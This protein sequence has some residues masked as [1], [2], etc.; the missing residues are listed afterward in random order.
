MVLP[1][2]LRQR[3]VKIPTWPI[4]G[5]TEKNRSRAQHVVVHAVSDAFTPFAISRDTE[6]DSGSTRGA[7]VAQLHAQ[8]RP[9][10]RKKIVVAHRSR[11][12]TTVVHAL[13]DAFTPF[14]MGVLP[15]LFGGA[16]G[17]NRSR[18][19][20]AGKNRSR[21]QR[22]CGRSRPF[23]RVHALSRSACWRSR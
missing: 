11:P 6:V 18:Q 17:K 4:S 3:L 5:P 15:G 21:A 22:P 1:N 12:T 2:Y 16:A 10:Y 14:E 23:R 7:V 9:E 13:S 19:G 8:D 20:C